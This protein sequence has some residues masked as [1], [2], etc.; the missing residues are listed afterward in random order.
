M[1]V[2]YVE[3]E[4]AMKLT[5]AAFGES[6][7]IPKRHG[8][9]FD[10]VSP[11]L[12]W[13]S[14]PPDATSFAL[15]VVDRISPGNVYLHWLVCDIPAIATSLEEGASGSP[16][17]PAGSRELRPY[18]G[19]FPPSGTHTY[20]FTLYALRAERLDVPD[21][22]S[23][24]QFEEAVESGTVETATLTGRFTSAEP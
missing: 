13:E 2:P 11:S 3:K 8:K 4:A 10:N 18:V 23:L 9:K 19:P 24:E 14:A 1:C 22:A 5:S 6:E 21:R 7:Q 20:E 17:M 15:A 16:Q 12:S